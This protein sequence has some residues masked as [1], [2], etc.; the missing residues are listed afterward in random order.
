[1]GESPRGSV[2][3]SAIGRRSPLRGRGEVAPP[4][5]SDSDST[6]SNVS[7]PHGTSHGT[8]HTHAAQREHYHPLYRREATLDERTHA[9]LC[10][11]SASAAA[12]PAHCADDANDGASATNGGGST[13][14]TTCGALSNHASN[15]ATTSAAANCSSGTSPT[16]S[17]FAE[18]PSQ[19]EPPAA[20]G[21]ASGLLYDMTHLQ[22]PRHAAADDAH[23]IASARCTA[24]TVHTWTR[25]HTTPRTSHRRSPPLT[26]CVPLRRV[27]PNQS[28]R[29]WSFG[30]TTMGRNLSHRP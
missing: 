9:V 16:S 7:T 1:M 5:D 19:A 28:S 22:V 2:A 8:P 26:A 27:C 11:A 20:E 3:R 10:A 15:N 30:R 17:T 12:R 13:S 14:S 23:T 29:W 6:A 21:G 18:E 4:S 25:A 24:H